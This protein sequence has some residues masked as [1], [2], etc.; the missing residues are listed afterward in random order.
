MAGGCVCTA[1]GL[2]LR[3]LSC[4]MLP[5]CRGDVTGARVE[6]NRNL[7]SDLL[8]VF[9]ELVAAIGHGPPRGHRIASRK[10][11]AILS[12]IEGTGADTQTFHFKAASADGGQRA[13]MGV[14]T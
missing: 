11:C 6:R 5:L 2:N 7:S 9:P 4:P 12:W 3:R 8:L 1:G 14:P 10:Q 13:Y